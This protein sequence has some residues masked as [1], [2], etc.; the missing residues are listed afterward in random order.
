MGAVGPKRLQQ[1]LAGE[2]AAAGE[3]EK[4]EERLRFLPAER[5]H[6]DLLLADAH[7]EPA[8][9]PHV[10]DRGRASRRT[11]HLWADRAGLITVARGALA[12]GPRAL[13][14]K[15]IAPVSCTFG[16]SGSL[17]GARRRKRVVGGR[18]TGR[19]GSLLNR[20]GKRHHQEG[21]LPGHGSRRRTRGQVAGPQGNALD[22]ACV[23]GRHEARRLLLRKRPKRQGGGEGERP[24]G[25]A[26]R[27]KL[28]P[29]LRK[30]HHPLA[31]MCRDEG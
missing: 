20:P 24:V 31:N 22:C 12:F 28:A 2:L 3:H 13:L 16:E 27:Y 10:E 18:E 23:L 5:L 4:R 21:A 26:T 30:G 17:Y 25:H 11:R 9:E 7:V 8:E 19:Q 15:R 29:R 1:A 6:V 14:A